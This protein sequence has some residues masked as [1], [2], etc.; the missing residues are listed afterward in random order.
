MADTLTN[1]QKQYL[2]NVYFD[3]KSPVAFSGINKTWN[4]IR[5]D[6]KVTKKQLV[7]WLLSQ[8]S[9]TSFRPLKKNFKRPRVVSPYKNYLWMTDTA[10][11]INFKEN[12]DGYSFFVVFIDTF[13]RHLIAY[14]LKTLRASEMIAAMTKAF[15]DQKCQIMYSDA[16]TEYTA[17]LVKAFLKKEKVSQYF[18]RSDT[19][20]SMAERVI[21]TIKG[22][23][24]KYM[25]K[26]NSFKWIDVLQDF[27][28]AYNN[29]FHTSI[30]MT[31]N[32]AQVSTQY[33]VWTNQYQTKPKRQTKIHKPRKAL[34]FKFQPGDSVKI[35]AFQYPFQREYDQHFTSE[36]FIVTDKRKKGDISLYKIKDM[37]NSGII[38]EFQD[39]EL[40]KVIVPK[41][42]V[43][44]INKVIKK[45]RRNKKTEYFVSWQGWPKQ[46]NSWV[47]NI[48]DQ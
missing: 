4:F 29:S 16:G 14:P 33:K 11:M 48:Q 18:S 2:Q 38:G 23:L 21:K 9:F 27:V 41:D 3:S 30:K 25:D 26:K 19:K 45:R 32:E 43:Y 7:K 39:Q 10:Y 8:D 47:D 46:F 34:A 28:S 24:L 15:Q 20:S 40:T 44:K 37:N 13:T 17:K 5:K 31:P 36:V 1:D 12:N 35:S 6:N 22:K 42:K